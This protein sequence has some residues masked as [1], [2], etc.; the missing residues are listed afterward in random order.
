MQKTADGIGYVSTSDPT[1]ETLG[2]Q[3]KRQTVQPFYRQEAGETVAEMGKQLLGELERSV[4]N[5]RSKGI[6]GKIYIQI[7]EQKIGQNLGRP[8]VKYTFYTRRTRPTPEWNTVLYSHED[9]DSCP[10]FEYALPELVH[11]PGIMKHS[12]KYPPT[13]IEMIQ[14]ML[15]GKLQ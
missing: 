8:V 13:Y 2:T 4:H 6:T 3:I 5:A 12:W 9:Q 14:A 10:K 1:R 11:I 7:L 15:K